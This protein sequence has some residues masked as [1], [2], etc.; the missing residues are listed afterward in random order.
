MHLTYYP[1]RHQNL[2]T[3]YNIDYPLFALLVIVM[4][5]RLAE[6]FI[7]LPITSPKTV[8]I[9]NLGNQNLKCK[10]FFF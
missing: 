1:A 7:S 5:R 9:A 6:S 4:M 8:T 2:V 10:L 3:E